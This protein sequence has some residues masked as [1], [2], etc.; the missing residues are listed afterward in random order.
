[1]G[2]QVKIG[3]IG[4]YDFTQNAH[5]ATNLSLDH[6]ANFLDIDISYYWIRLHEVIKFK[7]QQFYQYDGFLIAPG[8]ISNDFFMNSLMRDLFRM[9]L[10]ILI[11]GE[12]FKN[13]IE[14]LAT[15]HQLSASGEKI[16]SDNL[17]KGNQFERVTLTPHSS[18]FIELYKYRTPIELTSCRFSLYPHL[19]KPLEAFA[20]DVEAYNEFDEP[21]IVS[22]KTHPFFVASSF[23]PQISSTREFAH[24][25]IY[26]FVKLCTPDFKRKAN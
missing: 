24:P 7:A 6:A 1:M 23:S 14:A 2:Q 3:I 17:V 18:S 11:T 10:P 26:T 9:D 5:H 25:I 15:V 22:L 12:G 20:L 19:L 4:D 16:I 8:V 13:F 21:E